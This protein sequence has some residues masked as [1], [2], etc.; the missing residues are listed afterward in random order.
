MKLTT[1]SQRI[2][3][4][5]V[6]QDFAD[7]EAYSDEAQ[8]FEFFASKQI[9]KKAELSD[10][11]VERG[12]LG[13]GNDGGC[14]AVY[15]LFNNA[16][17]TEDALDDILP[18]KESCIDFIIVQAKRETS[19]C[20][21]AL[22]KWKTTT[23]N[24]LEI[25]ID[26]IQY[27]KRYNE[28]VLSAFALF[29]DLYVKVLRSTPKLNI[30]FHYATYAAE[31]HPN[32]QAQANELKAMVHKLF[33]SSKTTVTVKFWGAEE[34]LLA[35]QSQSEHKLNLPLAETPI[36][37][38]THQDYVA[39]VNLAKYYRF[40]TD[41]NGSLRKYI[42]EANVRDY[43]GHNAVN[44]DIEHTLA[45]T[46]GED[47]W[48]LNNGI[49]LLTDEATLAT[50]KELVLTEPAV[51]NGLQ[52]SNEIFRHFQANPDELATE[53][54]NVLVRII[55]P[56]SEDS[57]DRII[58]ATNNQT[59][60]PKSSLRANDPIH[61]QIELYLKGRG[62]YYDRRKNYYK[63]QGK[64]SN[65]IISV[66]F[67]AQCMISLLLQKPNYARAR[68]STLLT[69][70]ETYNTLYVENQ[71]LDVFYHAAKLGRTVELCLKKSN[72]YSQAQKN[73]ILFYVLYCAVAQKLGK[74]RITASDI[75]VIDLTTYTDDYILEV[76]TKV[77]SE[78]NRLGGDGKVAKGA[79]LIAVLMNAFSVNKSPIPV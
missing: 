8:F 20:E 11:E 48:W 6:K 59:N 13:N 26:D 64:K 72:A 15:T 9:M 22:M 75:R 65:E 77:F 2:L 35:A 51:V 49:T 12:V 78:Y 18:M 36:N 68:P 53:T 45:T 70:D 52:T 71:N 69:Q 73:D 60:I 58:L 46:T 47:F 66:S 27:A 79:E 29:R 63:N 16:C 23:G 74:N 24:L 43:Q 4:E 42:F 28:D 33:P 3:A 14:D 21:D 37:I 19:F 50:S 30:S 7:T 55:V 44:Q 61:W 40:I 1:N 31:I 38:G 57:R 56:E 39:L 32:V 76:A 67:L 17:V 25:G 54:R 34:I 10:E 41:E 5:M 62:L